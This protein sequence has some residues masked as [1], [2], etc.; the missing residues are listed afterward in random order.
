MTSELKDLLNASIQSACYLESLAVRLC[1]E[2][3][4]NLKVIF[5]QTLANLY[6]NAICYQLSGMVGGEN[7]AAALRNAFTNL[8]SYAA[9]N[10]NPNTVRDTI[11]PLQRDIL[12]SLVKTFKDLLIEAIKF[13]SNNR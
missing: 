1:I 12:E 5:I 7:L 2:N 3:S 4:Y 6:I 8:I 10:I 9:D 11:S 13:I